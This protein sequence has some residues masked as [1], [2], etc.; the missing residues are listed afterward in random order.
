[1]AAR[2]VSALLA[3]PVYRW[4]IRQEADIHRRGRRLNPGEMEDARQIGLR[5]A[6]QVRILSVTQIPLPAGAI[7]KMIGRF[8]RVVLADPVALTAG[9][10]I[11]CRRHIVDP[12]GALRHELVHVHQYERL[13][14]R[15]FLR[16]YIRDCLVDGYEDSS[17]EKEAR[18]RAACRP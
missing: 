6:G 9:H 2:W 7:L 10:G 17:L 1:V 14:R 3:P 5:H 11:Y 18:Q 12:R 4:L 13:G 8:S 16:R 15:A